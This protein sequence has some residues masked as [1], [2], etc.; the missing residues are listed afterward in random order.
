MCD[1]T[2]SRGSHKNEP[3]QIDDEQNSSL[4]MACDDSI[5]TQFFSKSSALKTSQNEL[6]HTCR[7]CGSAGGIVRETGSGVRCYAV[8]D[9]CYAINSVLAW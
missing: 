7:R 1:Q 8:C 2:G 4:S 6:Q 5:E 9:A 3:I